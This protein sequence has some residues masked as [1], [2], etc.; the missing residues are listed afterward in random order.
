MISGGLEA[1]TL[2]KAKPM[3]CD[4][5][6]SKDRCYQSV[7]KNHAEGTDKDRELGLAIGTAC[8]RDVNDSVALDTSA[9]VADYYDNLSKLVHGGKA[10]KVAGQKERTIDLTAAAKAAGLEAKAETTGKDIMGVI[11]GSGIK[12]SGSAKGLADIDVARSGTKDTEP[13]GSLE[14]KGKV[15]VH[16]SNKVVVDVP[17]KYSWG[18]LPGVSYGERGAFVAGEHDQLESSKWLAALGVTVF[19]KDV[20]SLRFQAGILPP[21][22]AGSPGVCASGRVQVNPGKTESKPGWGEVGG[23]VAACPWATSDA[24]KAHNKKAAIGKDGSLYGGIDV[25]GKGGTMDEEEPNGLTVNAAFSFNPSGSEV[26]EADAADSYMVNAG[27]EAWFPAGIKKWKLMA[28]YEHGVAVPKVSTGADDPYY[29]AITGGVTMVFSDSIEVATE[30]S[31][32]LGSPASERQDDLEPYVEVTSIPRGPEGEPGDLT[33]QGGQDFTSVSIV[34]KW[35]FTDKISL[36]A[37]W[38]VGKFTDVNDSSRSLIRHYFRT[39]LEA[40]FP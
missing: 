21:S 14:L 3:L 6:K 32:G 28:S 22:Q 35:H 29:H 31:K 26:P 20:L 18:T 37:G 30:F 16:E 4:A 38:S 39:V 7:E 12:V 2:A 10:V 13:G 8:Y 11:K 36:G 9:C 27:V 19:P 34:P 5:S 1:A 15:V 23:A 24:W 40:R 17:L 25:D 33:F